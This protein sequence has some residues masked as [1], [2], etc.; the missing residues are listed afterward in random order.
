MSMHDREDV[1][2]WQLVV[3]GCVNDEALIQSS[4][5]LQ[6]A[7]LLFGSTSCNISHT[8]NAHLAASSSISSL[9]PR[10]VQDRYHGTACAGEPKGA[11]A[12]PSGL[13]R[14]HIHLHSGN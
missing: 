1:H 5:I 2:H 12:Q 7:S 11:L 4:V 14:V 10:A 8:A 3:R 9:T 13:E 6:P